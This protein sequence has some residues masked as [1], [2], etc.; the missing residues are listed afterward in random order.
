MKLL[1]VDDQQDIREGIA[2]AIDWASHGFE[3]CAAAADGNEALDLLER[4]EPGILVVDISM[5]VMDGLELLEVVRD[6]HPMVRVIL[7]SGYDDFSYARRAVELHAFAYLL[8]PLS[9]SELV[10]KARE[11]RRDI[12][13]QRRRLREDEE[14]RRRL[15]EGLP[16]LR[17]DF[18]ARIAAGTLEE[19][20]GEE[21][22]RLLGIPTGAGEYALVL[23]EPSAPRLVSGEAARDRHLV[24]MALRRSV[25]G[26]F[27]EAGQCVPFTF[28]DRCGVLLHGQRLDRDAILAACRSARQWANTELGVALSVGVGPVVTRFADLRAAFQNALAALDYRMIIGGNEIV[29]FDQV[30]PS[31]RAGTAVDS[32]RRGLASS[33]ARVLGALAS[34]GEIDATRLAGELVHGLTES[35][36]EDG[37]LQPAALYLL[38]SRIA[39]MRLALRLEFDPSDVTE[40]FARLRSCR[41]PAALAAEVERCLAELRRAAECRLP[42]H[43]SFIVERAMSFIRDNI[44]SDVSLSAVARALLVHPNHLSRVFR[45]ATGESFLEHATRMKISEA[46][47][48]LR[49]STDR[50]YQIAD[51]VGYRDVE[52]FT[53]VFKR[54]VGV[55]PSRYREMG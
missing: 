20:D 18:F 24:V 43:S 2:R 17:D 5:P 52:H 50:V 25:A 14:L 55:S 36:G 32:W 7:I 9:E 10:A 12:E 3:L 51:T 29:P 54:L 45:Q 26:S 22:A 42:S 33:A 8:K 19:T 53:R 46:Q 30:Q 11:A 44:H 40:L 39:E 4:F 21:R 13:E 48:L 23:L 49:E 16:V 47:R 1:I 35:A 41:A 27:P 31:F 15:D 6:R 34:G 38:A 37:A 28:H